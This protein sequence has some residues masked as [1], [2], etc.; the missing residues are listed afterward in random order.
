MRRAGG[1]IW[2][3][4]S[5]RWGTKDLDRGAGRLTK[6]TNHFAH[7]GR[8]VDQARLA[9]YE[10]GPYKGFAK[11]VEKAFGGHRAGRRRRLG[12]VTDR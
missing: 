12:V 9:E 2:P 10:A 6:G 5:S 7:S 11:S 4:S 1:A 8:P 3:A